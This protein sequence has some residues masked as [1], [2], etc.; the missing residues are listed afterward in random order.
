MSGTPT[1]QITNA[2]NA[3]ASISTPTGPWIN[4]VSFSIGAGYGYTPLP[5]DTGLSGSTLFTGTPTSYQNVGDGTLDILCEIPPNAGPFQFGEIALYLPGNVMFAKAVFPTPQTKFSAL[6]TNVVSSYELH[7]LLTLAQGTAVFQITTV[8]PTTL[9]QVYSWSDIYPPNL[10]ANP[11]VPL[12]QVMELSEYGDSTLL[13]NSSAGTWTI[14]STY[15]RYIQNNDSPS[16]QVMNAST[17]WVEVLASTLHQLDLT[18]VNERFVINTSDGYYRSVSSVVTSG[19]N[20]RFNLNG[21]PLQTVP[22]AGSNLVIYRDDLARGASYYSQILDPLDYDFTN[23]APDIGTTNAYAATYKQKDPIPKVGMIRS[24]LVSTINTGASTFALD[25]GAP[26]PV[27]GMASTPLQGGEMNGRVWLEFSTTNNWVLINSTAGPL[28]IPNALHT[29]QAFPLGQLATLGNQAVQSTSKVNGVNS[30]NLL[31]NSSAEFMTA[32]WS[33]LFVPTQDVSG[34][35]SYWYSPAVTGTP[36]TQTS[37]SLIP[38]IPGIPINL[39]AEIY[40]L[41]VTAGDFSVDI[42]FLSSA[43]AVIG[44]LRLGTPANGLSWTYY[45]STAIVP[46]GTAYLQVRFFLENTPTCTLGGAAIR[47]IKVEQGN[48][49]SIYSQEAT[50]AGLPQQFLGMRSTFVTNGSLTV[51]PNVYTMWV[52]GCGAGGGGGSGGG[53]YGGAVG[54]GG[55]G[56]GAGEPIVCI[57]FTVTP[58]TLIT[59][60]LGAAGAGGTNPNAGQGVA[61]FAGGATVISGGISLTLSGGGPGEGGQSTI[62]SNAAGAG[63]GGGYPDGGMGSDT[64][65]T[66]PIGGDGGMGASSPFGGGGGNGRGGAGNGIIAYSASGY[67]AGGGGGGGTYTPGSGNG[68][69]GGAGVPGY[70]LLEW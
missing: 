55:A 39:S 16:F 30:A 32:G 64:C 25:G 27:Y 3:A 70:V 23:Y 69:N 47:R 68:G 50:I 36:T 6:G 22:A 51:P 20:Y 60:A 59:V 40:T 41:G 48:L 17:T 42:Q 13:S 43:E 31:F 67:G 28:Q 1:F 24:F 19:L 65:W 37:T 61:G 33:G 58:G 14:D 38:V 54:A 7:C 9:L 21:T 53:G 29:Q 4:I 2:G 44:D 11:T 45:S 62:G 18:T 26:Y 57:P 15:G 34:S 10:S 52:S 56:G 5:T 66:T 63:A 46:A 8:V 35:G 12:I 49:P